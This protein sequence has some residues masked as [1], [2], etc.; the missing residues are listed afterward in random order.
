MLDTRIKMRLKYY[1][2]DI[3]HQGDV[4]EQNLEDLAE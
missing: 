4:A 1:E 2:N 3:K